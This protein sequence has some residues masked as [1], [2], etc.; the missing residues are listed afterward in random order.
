LVYGD[1]R[2][3]LMRVPEEILDSVVFLVTKE[4]QEEDCDKEC[5]GTAFFVSVRSEANKDWGYAYLVTAKHNI[6]EAKKHGLELYVRLNTKN[7]KSEDIR[8][9]DDWTYPADPSV[10]LAILKFSPGRPYWYRPLAPQM[11]ADE[12]RLKDLGVG[13]GDEIVI[14]GLFTRRTGKEK[15]LP[16]VRFG[17]IAAMPGEPLVDS[18]TG[19][20]YQAYLVEVRS[21][22]G[23]SGSPV[24]V[25]FGSDRMVP[26]GAKEEPPEG[27][28][29]LILLGVLRSHWEHKEPIPFASAFRDELDKINWGVAVVTPATE[30]L[31]I[32]FSEEFVKQRKQ[33]DREHE[34]RDAPVDDFAAGK[35]DKLFT[36]EDFEAALKKASRKIEPRKS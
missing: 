17:N 5:R 7:G 4:P 3:L 6:T 9:D 24:F 26:G 33:I 2:K 35:K 23:L 1:P 29:M 8:I 18:K 30:I 28:R 14:S 36:K 12:E 15:N 11:Q 22:G 25:Y 10:D 31:P 19:F 13:I 34:N 27:L 16:I 20:P 21:F 32:L